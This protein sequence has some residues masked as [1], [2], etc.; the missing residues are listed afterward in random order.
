MPI[1]FACPNCGKKFSAAESLA[2][3][4]RTCPK[5]GSTVTVPKVSEQKFKA[6]VDRVK[7]SVSG[8][9]DA[10]AGEEPLLLGPR[11]EQPE[12]LVDMTAMVDIVFFLLI[13][14]LVTS[15]QSLESVINM[16]AP[17]APSAAAANVRQVPDFDNDP[18]Y[19]SVT[20]E[21]D[22]SIW[23]DDEQVF[24]EQDLRAKLRAARNKDDQLTGLFVHGS[25]DASHG[26]F[27]MV[28]DAG[29]G[30]GLK[31]LMFSVTGQAD[32][33]DAG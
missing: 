18:S 3:K 1:A 25:A 13:F 15:M 9:H 19:I 29:A 17:Q 30:A 10:A 8:E 26:T 28:L 31:D 14:F 5:C 22:D 2:G 20:I 16:P 32:S 23:V 24:G 12:D 11:A 27:V 6:R 33:P 21:D 4:E 7:L